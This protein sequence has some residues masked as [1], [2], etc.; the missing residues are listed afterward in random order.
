MRGFVIAASL[1]VLLGAAPLLAQ[2]PTAPPG[3]PAGQKPAAPAQPAAP[4]PAVQ[5]PPAP[6]APFPEGARIAYVNLQFIAQQSTDG[7]AAA[8]RIQGEV[9]K[10]QDE[11]AKRQKALEDGKQKLQTGGTVMNEQA[12]SQLEKDLERQ[13]RELERFQQDAQADIQELERE[14]QNEFQKRLFPVLDQVAN[15]KGLHL[16]LNVPNETVLWGV[17]GL[18]L[19]GEVVKKLDA[20]AAKPAA[21]PK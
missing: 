9:K 4:P 1:A 7:K 6:P 21:A 8:T 14:A 10:R 19:S 3:A 20:S 15:E 12:R 2:A 13:N 11:I 18:D 16:L 17:P 5:K